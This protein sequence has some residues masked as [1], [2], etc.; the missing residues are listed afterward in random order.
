M[1]CFYLRICDA[2]ETIRTMKQFFTALGAALAATFL[3]QSAMAR[4]AAP[5]TFRFIFQLNHPLVYSVSSTIK[6]LSD[7]TMQLD[8]GAKSSLTSNSV[9]TRYKVELTPVKESAEGVWTVSYKPMDFEQDMDFDAPGGH[10]VTSIRG[11][12]VKSTQ[13]GIV[14]VDTARD[15]GETQAKAIK[16]SVYSKM[17]SG[18][19]DF[20]PN[21]EIG[22]VDGDLPF[23]DNWTEAFKY[24][25]GFFDLVF[26]PGP[27][28]VG[29]RWNVSLDLK[30]LQGLK[31]GDQGIL[32]TNVFVRDGAVSGA[33]H[34]ESIDLNMAVSA[35]DVMGSTDEMGQRSML[36]IPKF[37]HDKTGTFHFDPEAGCVVNGSEDESVR[38]TMDTLVQ[39]HTL[40][41]TLQ[42]DNNTKFHL[43]KN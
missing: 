38:T 7:R 24:Q 41:T 28:A 22:K 37:D 8:T 18:Y 3:A 1:N 42:L 36:N 26:P 12:N 11:L 20:K 39:G 32:E 2:L 31:L 17:I 23:I 25:A 40:T 16:Q 9:E 34:L 27:V 10:V 4:D 19:F 13:N 21:G 29:G 30:D 15:I 5:Q 33:D 14:V 35:R 6:V 43:E